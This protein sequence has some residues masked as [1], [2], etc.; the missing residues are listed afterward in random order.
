MSTQTQPTAPSG[1]TPAAAA[2]Q[3][4]HVL[5]DEQRQ[6]FWAQ[7]EEADPQAAWSKKRP[8]RLAFDRENVAVRATHPGG[9]SISG[10]V[11]AHD[12]SAA[13]M[14]FLNQGYLH[15]GTLVDVVLPRRLSGDEQV[16]GRVAWCRHVGGTWHAVG[17]KFHAPVALKQFVSPA[18]WERLP[19]GNPARPESLAGQVLMIDDQE[20]DRLL[21]AHLL[22]ATRLT[23]TGVADVDQAVQSLRGLVFD[24]VCLDLN[25]G[26][27]RARGEDVV[28]SVRAAGH[29][30][31]IVV[32]SG[33]TA[34][35]LDAVRGPDVE[36]VLAKPY[37]AD[38]LLA[39]LAA[40]LGAGGID[41]ADRLY[42]DLSGEDGSGELL[43]QF[44]DKV[45]HAMRDFRR[46]VE[47]GR[48]DDVRL[49]CQM[50]RGTAA[51]YGFPAV[52]AAAAAGIKALDACG[53]VGEASPDLHKLTALCKRI[54]PDKRPPADG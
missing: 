23:I 30:G 33:E 7:H 38:Q 34:A 28:K 14:S 25:L 9:G 54:T 47:A 5:S 42:S 41:P 17:V 8:P 10:A 18:D 36:H 53:D 16:E 48:A 50:L 37:D 46:H 51:G 19:T 2:H 20:I 52:A 13:G 43:R 35:R 31:P 40:A 11:Y 44:C 12:L 3:S 29:R 22:R 45:Q 27:G 21:F 32:I 6:T 24:L 4:A 15:V 49:T 39:V 1:E 26:V